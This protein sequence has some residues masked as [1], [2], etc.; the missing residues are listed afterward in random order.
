[1]HDTFALLH[2]LRTRAQAH[3]SPRSSRAVQWVTGCLRKARV[4][5]CPS[6]A[7]FKFGALTTFWVGI[8][9]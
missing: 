5:I 2:S 8:T 1:M 7:L 6:E 4:T 3:T 9:H